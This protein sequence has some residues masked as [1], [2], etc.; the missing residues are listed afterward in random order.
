MLNTEL[1]AVHA[2]IVVVPLAVATVVFRR[3]AARLYD[4]ARER[5]AIVN[6]DFQE[7]LSGVRE[8]QAFVHEARDQAALPPPRP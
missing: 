4:L 3:K 8:A 2:L 1:G 6:A 5:I 7:S